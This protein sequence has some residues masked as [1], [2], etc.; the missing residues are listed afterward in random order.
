MLIICNPILKIRTIKTK[1]KGFFA[2]Q[3]ISLKME[4]KISLAAIEETKVEVDLPYTRETT[5]IN[6]YKL[7][8]VQ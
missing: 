8:T 2:Y 5:S 7:S 4:A 6:L 1:D 3:T